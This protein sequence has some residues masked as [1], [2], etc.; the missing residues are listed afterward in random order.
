MQEHDHPLLLANTLLAEEI[1]WIAKSSPELPMRCMAKTR[2]RQPDQ[3]CT[4]YAGNTAGT[5]MVVFE[6]Q[7]RA[8]TPGQSVVFYQDD[9]CLGGGIINNVLTDEHRN[10]ISAQQGSFDKKVAC[11]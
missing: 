9:I 6:E 1:N 3:A 4:I 2:Y 10:L 8:I 7:Q 11:N 5:L